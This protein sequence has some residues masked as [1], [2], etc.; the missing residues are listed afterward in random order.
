MKKSHIFI[1]L[2]LLI[3]LVVVSQAF[4]QDYINTFFNTFFRSQDIDVLDQVLQSDTREEQYRD[5]VDAT[6]DEL[7]TYLNLDNE[8]VDALYNKEGLSSEKHDLLQENLENEFAAL[9]NSGGEMGLTEEEKLIRTVEILFKLQEMNLFDE[10]GYDF[11]FLIADKQNLM[12]GLQFF[13]DYSELRRPIEG[14]QR[15]TRVVRP[16]V[17]DVQI[18]GDVAKVLTTVYEIV[19]YDDWPESGGSTPNYEIDFVM[20]GGNWF[21]SEIRS[22][23]ER[24]AYHVDNNTRLDVEGI[25]QSLIDEALET[26][27]I[28]QEM[29]AA[30]QNG[31]AVE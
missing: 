9:A 31:E 12:P 4:A 2:A 25:R 27:R 11:D 17:T 20:S 14:F 16:F 28:L 8:D 15:H 30:Q 6:Y 7:Q 18:M 29:E 23:N 1:A 24:E 26:E 22:D 13:L 21:I 3:V 19:F 5:Y 10:R